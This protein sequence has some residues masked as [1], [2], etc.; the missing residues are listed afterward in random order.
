[1]RMH[2]DRRPGQPG[3]R[4]AEA[5]GELRRQIDVLE[6]ELAAATR[7]LGDIRSL[8]AAI[9]RRAM[10]AVRAGHDRAARDALIELHPHV[11]AAALIE[12]DI[13]VLRALLAECHD[14]LRQSSGPS[15]A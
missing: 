6:A 5:V 15:A 13:Q 4:A 8:S 2:F 12:A 3:Q 14:F 7:T 1:M 10:D 9:E 11:E